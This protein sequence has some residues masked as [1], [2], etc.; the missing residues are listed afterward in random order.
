MSTHDSWRSGNVRRTYNTDGKLQG[1]GLKVSQGKEN[2]TYLHEGGLE[3]TCGFGSV[4]S[5]AR[6][7]GGGQ[8]AKQ[9]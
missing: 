6:K 9:D 7:L 1:L 8:V 3:E 2:V 5:I 4:Y